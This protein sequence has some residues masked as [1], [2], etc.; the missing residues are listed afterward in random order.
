MKILIGIGFA[1]GC[2]LIGATVITLFIKL[3]EFIY[4]NFNNSKFL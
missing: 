3:M 1:I 4:H 2:A